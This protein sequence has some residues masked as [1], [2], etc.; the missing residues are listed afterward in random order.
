MRVEHDVRDEAGLGPG[1]VLHGPLPAADALL[2]GTRR[3]LVADG[4][5]ARDPAGHNSTDFEKKSV[6][7][8]VR[9][10]EMALKWI[11]E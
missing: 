7:K 1:Q 3:E 9:E 6:I 8:T 5:V 4:R 11:P 2:A 10:M